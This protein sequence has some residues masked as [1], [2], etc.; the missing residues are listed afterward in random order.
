M[1][2]GK[3][4]RLLS[5]AASNGCAARLGRLSLAGRRVIETPSYFAVTSRGC[6]PHL[7][8]D[9]LSK[10]TSVGAAYMA[11]EDFVERAKP[12]VYEIPPGDNGR[13][14]SFTALPTDRA[15]VLGA[16]RCLP[17]FPPMGNKRRSVTV[18]T[19]TGFIDITIGEYAAAVQ[20]LQP[21]MV[22]ALGDALH[23]NTHPSVKK[24]VRMA[25]RTEDWVDEFIQI[26]GGRQRIDELGMAVFAPVLPVV[27]PLQSDYLRHLA[28]DVTEALSGLAIYDISLLP[29][30]FGYPQLSHLAKLS[31]EAP[32]TPHEVLRQVALGVDICTIPFVNSISDAGVALTFTFPPPAA[33]KDEPLGTNMWS[34]E[35]AASLEPALEGCR[36]Y[37][38]TRHHRAY[39]HHLL[40][41]KEMLGWTLLQIHNHH[42]MSDFFAGVRRSL[43][44]GVSHFE[45]AREDF[46]RAYEAELPEGTGERPRA[47][48]YH[49]KSA[50]G[51]DKINKASWT[52]LEGA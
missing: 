5:S 48:G 43:D 41:A 37:A 22:V 19:S 28:E 52:D 2:L 4:F 3:P 6:V 25:E 7:T 18:F 49:F 51:Q 11:L 50:V 8:P 45:R 36:C 27:F 17:V 29:D 1:H 44:Q 40:S 15:T 42:V 32:K 10:H 38:C 46:T 47:R 21:D 16:R 31:L 33:G 24:Q 14:H 34:T 26:L 20:Q 30:L 9:S 35:H 39:L 12:P 23:K 13:L